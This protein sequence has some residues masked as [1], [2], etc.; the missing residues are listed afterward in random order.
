MHCAGMILCKEWAD[1]VA[2]ALCGIGAMITSE[3]RGITIVYWRF[4]AG[5]V[6][7]LMWDGVRFARSKTRQSKD[8]GTAP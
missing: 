8:G 6:P 3:T 4:Q 2:S 7:H 5:P 1:L